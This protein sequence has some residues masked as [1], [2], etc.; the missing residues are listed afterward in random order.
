MKK[1]LVFATNNKHKAAEIQQL[2]G[3][4]Y[5]IKTLADIGC[6]DDIEETGLTLEENASI[7][8]NYVFNKYGLSC[9]ADD[10]GLEVDALNGAPGVYSARYAG[11]QKKDDDNMDLLLSNLAQYSSKKAKFRTVVSCII[12]GTETMFEGILEGA[13][14]SQRA[15]TN[16]FGYDPIFKPA[17]LNRTLAEMTT[18]EKNEISHRARAT[19]KLIRFL[20]E[21]SGH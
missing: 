5:E 2:V 4:A 8:S 19:R 16:G 10:T 13:I 9:F 11:A 1:I 3:D 14:V 15:G 12:N 7:K 18:A 21:Q 17:D 20:N 6:H